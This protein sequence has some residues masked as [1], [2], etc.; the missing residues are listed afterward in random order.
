MLC[1]VMFC[2]VLFASYLLP[3]STLSTPLCT[4]R[5]FLGS[6][7]RAYLCAMYAYATRAARKEL[8][9][10]IIQHLLTSFRIIMQYYYRLSIGHYSAKLQKISHLANKIPIKIGY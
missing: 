6:F 3:I 10:I 2:F 8:R 9:I 4:H 1:Y 5:L 7:M